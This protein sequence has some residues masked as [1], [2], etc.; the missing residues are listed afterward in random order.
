MKHDKHLNNQ[1]QK[2]FIIIVINYTFS[3]FP[4]K[5]HVL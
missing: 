2:A 5:V 1:N 3:V 4:Q